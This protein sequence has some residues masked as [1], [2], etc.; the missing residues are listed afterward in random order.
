MKQ[1]L[2]KAGPM[3]LSVL[4]AIVVWGQSNLNTTPQADH[5]RLIRQGVIEY[6]SG[7]YAASQKLFLDALAQISE[8]DELLRAATLAKLGDV[9]ASEEEFS[10]AERAYSDALRIYNVRGD[11][12]QRA[13]M[14]HNIGMLYSIL[15]RSDDALRAVNQ[16][17]K[18]AKAASTQDPS[19]T[20][21]LL[22]GLGIIH[23]RRGQDGKAEKY[24]NQ[25]LQLI[26][27]SS[28]QFERSKALN[29]LA[30]VYFNQRRFKQAK[31]VYTRALQTKE[32]EVGLVHHDLIGTLN[33]LGAVNTQMGNYAEAIDHYRRA[34]GI[35]R[36]ADFAPSAA[37]IL[38]QLSLTYSLSGQKDE[39]Q[40]ALA[41]AAE[42]ARANLEKA[43]DLAAILNDYAGVLK[44]QGRTREA[45]EL[46]R[47]AK[48]A[49]T[50]SGMV[51]RAQ[52]LF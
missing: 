17:R 37:R 23:Y 24:F 7:H 34:L 41:E 2:E 27:S 16:G 13:L 1:T 48:Q 20:A 47:Q 39:A 38:H 31:E 9:Y 18:L 46:S 50:V 33:G 30:S 5:V 25:L 15:G 11:Q 4:I 3:M 43:P 35:L 12:N 44:N 6:Q 10:K 52:T 29:N 28:V 8:S 51:V 21:L 14:L 49:R 42:L 32:A 40:T 45:D 26:E 22:N 19:I 36:S